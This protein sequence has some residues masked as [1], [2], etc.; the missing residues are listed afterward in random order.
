PGPEIM[1][2]LEH[3]LRADRSV[4]ASGDEAAEPGPGSD[5]ADDRSDYGDP[6]DSGGEDGGDPVRNI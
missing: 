3:S 4:P 2:A 6:G 5:V 1:D